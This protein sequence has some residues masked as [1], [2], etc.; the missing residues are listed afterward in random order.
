MPELLFSQDCMFGN[1]S[2]LILRVAH[3]I[4]TFLKAI[5]ENF[6]SDHHLCYVQ[7]LWLFDKTNRQLK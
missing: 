6:P 5:F 4:I 1:D 7:T 2:Y 3:Q